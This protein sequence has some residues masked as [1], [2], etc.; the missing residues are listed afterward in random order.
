MSEYIKREALKNAIATSTEPFTAG[1]VFKTINDQPAIDVASV[2]RGVL[3]NW[4]R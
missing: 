2:R 4:R 3:E 1:L